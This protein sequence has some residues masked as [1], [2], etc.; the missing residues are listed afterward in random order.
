MNES[1]C[2]DDRELMEEASIF[3]FG[4]FFNDKKDFQDIDLLVLHKSTTKEPCK[5]ALSCK[6]YL[7]TKIPS[8]HITIL[9]KN[10]ELQQNFIN[11]SNAIFL[12][13][14]YEK[15]C[16]ETINLIIDKNINNKLN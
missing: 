3:G 15:S 4:S 1:N 8:V 13:K 9:S 12:G 16:F 10:G 11:K 7:K 2:Q 14:V 6:K 5:F